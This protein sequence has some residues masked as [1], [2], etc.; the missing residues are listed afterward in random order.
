M[1]ADLLSETILDAEIILAWIKLN[2]SHS[3]DRVVFN[4]GSTG[5]EDRFEL[6]VRDDKRLFV[7]L[8]GA[9]DLQ[10]LQ[11]LVTERWYHVAVTYNGTQLILW[12]NG[13]V[14]NQKTI[15]LT[16]IQTTLYIGSRE[17]TSR[18]QTGEQ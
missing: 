17:G 13:E 14:D 9:Q 3:G 2:N 8:S 18:F 16:T 5:D 7:S 11:Y 4:Y 15:N 6:M 12:I 1:P 10:G